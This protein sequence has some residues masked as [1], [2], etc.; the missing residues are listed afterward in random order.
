MNFDQLAD[1]LKALSDPTRLKIIALLQIRDCC[2]CELVPL[3]EISQPAVSKHMSRL[4]N[5]DLVK[6]SRKGMWVFYSL[7]RDR[8]N[9]IGI[10][11]TNLPDLSEELRQLEQQGL[12]VQCD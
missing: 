6:E 10:S 3:F 2:V 9:E 5:A 4:K 8:L 11:L 7:N 12:L 1:T